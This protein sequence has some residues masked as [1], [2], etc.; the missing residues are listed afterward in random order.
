ML[1]S[2]NGSR[3]RRRIEDTRLLHGTDAHHSSAGLSA[4]GR[5]LEGALSRAPVVTVVGVRSKQAIAEPADNA[6]PLLDPEGSARLFSQI[7]EL[8]ITPAVKLRQEAGTLPR[9]VELRAAVVELFGDGRAAVVRINEEI[10]GIMKMQ[11][12]AGTGAKKAGDPI[13]WHEVDGIGPVQVGRGPLF[14]GARA[15]GA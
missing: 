14:D 6:E 15:P 2:G 3:F 8:W 9:P 5:D 10:T 13:Y 4:I 11:I 1:S 7:L 12:R